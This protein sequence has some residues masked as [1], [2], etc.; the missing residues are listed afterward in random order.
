MTDPARD[1]VDMAYVDPARAVE[2]AHAALTRGD[3]ADVAVL[4]RAMGVAQIL[5]GDYD[6][7][8]ETL[9]IAREAAIE[10]GDDHEHLLA[11]LTM[12]GPTTVV[13]TMSEATQLVESAAHLATTPYLDARL[14]YQRGVLAM[15]AGDSVQAVSQFEVSLPGLETAGDEVTLRAALQNLGLLDMQAGDLSRAE[16]HLED[17]L[18]IASARGEETAVSGIEHNL[19]L[20]AS[21]RGDITRA[22]ALLLDSDHI[23]MRLTGSAAPQHVARSEVLLSVG[24][25]DEAGALAVEI[26]DANRS[27][28]DTEHLADALIV[29]ARAA[30]LGGHPEDAET[31][32]EEAVGV[33]RS[34]RRAGAALEA[35][36]LA[37]DARCR[38]RGPSPDLFRR[39]THIVTVLERERQL[40][41]TAEA[42]LLIARLAAGLGDEAAAAAALEPVAAGDTGPVEA[43]V[44]ARVAR[45]KLCLL[46]DDGRGADA[47]ARSGL[48]LIDHYQEV[49]GATDIRMGLEQHGVELGSIGVDL[50]VASGDPRRVLQWMER[51]RARTLRHRPVSPDGRGGASGE[52]LARLRKVEADLREPS[53]QGD[54]RLE[55]ERRRLQEEVRT[56]DRLKKA[57]GP[58]VDPFDIAALIDTLGHR[59]LFE[60]GIHRERLIGVVV[61]NGRVRR[62]DL[63]PFSAVA[64]ELG[65]LRFAL[66]RAARLGRPLPQADLDRI[67][68]ALLAPARLGEGDLIVVPP[69][70]LM[71]MPWAALPSFAGRTLTVVPSAEMWWRANLARP[72]SGQVLVV[73]GPDLSTAA[74]EVQSVGALH[75]GALVLPPGSSV[76]ATLDA[77]EGAS[78]AHVA[79]HARFEAQNP[80]FSALRLGD[81]DLSVYDLERLE[82]PPETVVLSACDSGYTEAKEGVELAGLTSALLAMGTRS[83]VASVGLVPDHPATSEL[84]VRFHNGLQAGLH[85]AEALASA[86]AGAGDD[87]LGVVAAASF[88][89]VGG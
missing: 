75:G 13:G 56:A 60:I 12:A 3:V 88:V 78:I 73:G 6:T 25:F 21:Y 32:A 65:H 84:M 45:A 19:G 83:I 53:N 49:V 10:G 29:A 28:G 76:A 46:R 86:Q 14:A 11:V 47:A 31:L 17:A 35:E 8:L 77:I 27:K 40:L 7:A 82:V 54:P 48:R 37:I 33:Y 20:L 72:R 69:P 1:I 59:E 34:H 89:Y 85:G 43:R 50:A 4:H 26:A 71:A 52:T 51:T 38:L 5:L 41:P 87:P 36:M 18:A 44:R 2:L 80:M 64:G 55:R 42:R 16:L 61:S 58:R 62:V 22:L 67:D 15:R 39:A 74:S 24:L 63:G 9:G 68:T 70:P 79:C 23:Y 66:R 30:L 57:E 81:G